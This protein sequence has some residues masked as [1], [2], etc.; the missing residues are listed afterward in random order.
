MPVIHS[1]KKK[2]RQDRLRTKVNKEK[3]EILKKTL[4]LVRQKPTPENISKTQ[5]V[6]DKMAKRHL[7]HK[8]KAARLKSQV[9]KLVKSAKPRETVT[10]DDKS[11]IKRQKSKMQVKSKK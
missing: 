2:M 10:I 5:S 8:N 3:K 11:T 6:I 1:A 9:A 7:I 4:K